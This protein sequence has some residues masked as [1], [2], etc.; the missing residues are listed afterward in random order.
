MKPTQEDLMPAV[1]S[2]S[3]IA[4]FVLIGYGYATLGHKAAIWQRGRKR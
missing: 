1:I 2:L 3:R 4:L